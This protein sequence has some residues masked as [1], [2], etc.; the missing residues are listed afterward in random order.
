MGEFRGNGE[1]GLPFA[2]LGDGGPTRVSSGR[3]G[4]R[5]LPCG[6]FKFT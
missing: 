1:T 5:G 3:R 6:E 2:L 4:A